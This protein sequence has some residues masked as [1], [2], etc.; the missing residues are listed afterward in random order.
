MVTQKPISLKI[1][2]SV[3]ERLDKEAEGTWKS[4]NKLINEA[5]DMYLDL[6]DAK[7]YQKLEESQGRKVSQEALMFI[8]RNLVKNVQY[9]LDVIDHY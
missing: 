3:L 8:K 2:C 9:F 1:N 7:R 4:R 5:I 6:L